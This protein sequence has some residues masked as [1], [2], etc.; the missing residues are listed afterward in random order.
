MA[1]GGSEQAFAHEDH[2]VGLHRVGQGWHALQDPAVRA[3]AVQAQAHL[4]RAL[5]ED[6]LRDE[7]V[8][9]ML[10]QAKIPVAQQYALSQR[11]YFAALAQGASAPN[12]RPAPMP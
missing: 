5:S 4:E 3:D 6:A 11:K 10:S 8:R 7:M 9:V 1:A 2:V 12:R